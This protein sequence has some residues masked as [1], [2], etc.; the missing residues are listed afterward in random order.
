MLMVA[1]PKTCFQTHPEKKKIGHT[2]DL[3]RPASVVQKMST[4][5][6]PEEIKRK[7]ITEMEGNSSVNDVGCYK[8]SLKKNY[9]G[10]C[11]KSEVLRNNEFS[12]SGIALQPRI[13]PLT[14][15]SSLETAKNTL[16]FSQFR[17]NESIGI[18]S[19]AS[20][21]HALP[22]FDN[23]SCVQ[24]MWRASTHQKLNF[25]TFQIDASEN[26][27]FIVRGET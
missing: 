24:R 12:V 4:E 17:L 1:Y 14:L 5:E 23:V 22:E 18:S 25:K 8:F 26:Q 15:R 27:G 16:Y 7:L 19:M 3:S 2:G 6:S 13:F 20:Q 10:S 11:P 9:T 21:D